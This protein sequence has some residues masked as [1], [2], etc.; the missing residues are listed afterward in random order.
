[1]KKIFQECAKNKT[2]NLFNV[3]QYNNK[4]LEKN[5]III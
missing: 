1:M 4:I 5:Y 2:L 3:N